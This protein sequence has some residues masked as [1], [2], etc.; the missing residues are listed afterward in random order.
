[1]DLA[2]GDVVW[3]VPLGNTRDL[4]PADLVAAR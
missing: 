2:T 3:D 1:M 4:A